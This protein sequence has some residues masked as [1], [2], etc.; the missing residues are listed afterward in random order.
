MVLLALDIVLISF[1]VLVYSVI[2]YST[3]I[4]RNKQNF[5]GTSPKYKSKQHLKDIAFSFY[6]ILCL[7]LFYFMS[8][9]FY[10]MSLLFF[11]YIVFF[12]VDD[13]CAIFELFYNIFHRAYD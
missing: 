3:L 13:N 6:S 5:R 7:L 11:I 1:C 8:L 4:L 10:F 12:I 9:L 2:F